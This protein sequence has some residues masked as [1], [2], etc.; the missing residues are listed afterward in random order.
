[1]EKS[2]GLIFS[3]SVSSLL[4]KGAARCIHSR[5]Q[6]I[7]LQETS[8]KQATGFFYFREELIKLIT[9]TIWRSPMR[10]ALALPMPD[11]KLQQELVK[12]FRD[13]PQ[14]VT[15]TDVSPQILAM[16]DGKEVDLDELN[17]LAELNLF[18]S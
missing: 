7:N 4:H 1:V 17:F 12:V 10:T 8:P 15:A 18:N 5:S 9:L 6:E 11:E 3:K 14:K 16:L 2:A 13:T